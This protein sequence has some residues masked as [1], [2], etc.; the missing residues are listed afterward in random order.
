MKR[1]SLNTYDIKPAEMLAYLRYNGLHFN[2]K[3]CDY[4]VSLMDDGEHNPI[5]KEQVDELLQMYG[6]KLK[7]NVLYDYVYVANMCKSD[8]YGSAIE[9]DEHLVKYIQKTIDDKDGYDGMIFNRWYSD[10]C[11]KGIGIDWTSMV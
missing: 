10:M 2:K 11:G 4:A 9:D 5:T 3:M 7:Y 1:T 6:V 8:Y